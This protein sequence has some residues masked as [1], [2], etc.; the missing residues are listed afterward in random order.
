MGAF[1]EMTEDYALEA[2]LFAQD[3][4]CEA[5]SA[6]LEGLSARAAAEAMA[7]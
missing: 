7:S 5:E 3:S 6:V 2:I 4:I 1:A